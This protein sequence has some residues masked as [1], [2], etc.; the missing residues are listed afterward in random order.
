MSEPL[1]SE[2][3]IFNFVFGMQYGSTHVQEGSW[4]GSGFTVPFQSEGQRQFG[5]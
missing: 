2:A 4:R 3:P 5:D 1:E